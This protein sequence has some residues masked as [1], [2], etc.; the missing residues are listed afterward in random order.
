MVDLCYRGKDSLEY[1]CHLNT[2]NNYA[3]KST[4]LT[5]PSEMAY[6]DNGFADNYDNA[7]HFSDETPMDLVIFAPLLRIKDG[8]ITT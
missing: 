2:G 3:N 5:L 4:W 1:N 8:V 7:I 6:T